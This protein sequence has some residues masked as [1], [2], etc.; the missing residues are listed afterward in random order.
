MPPT[1][2]QEAKS[3]QKPAPTPAPVTPEQALASTRA[4]LEAKKLRARQPP[5]W[6][7]ADPYNHSHHEPVIDTQE[8]EEEK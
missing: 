6:P 1:K 5:P 4:L 3:A 8:S 2:R 7:N